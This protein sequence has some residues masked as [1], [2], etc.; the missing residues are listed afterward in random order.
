VA[1]LAMCGCGGECANSSNIQVTV[2]PDPGV[3][4]TTIVKLRVALA[5]NGIQVKAADLPLS[6]PLGTESAFLLRPASAQPGRYN[7]AVQI[8]ALAAHDVI[9]AS[10]SNEADVSGDGCNR[11]AARLAPAPPDNPG[12]KTMPMPACAGAMP[13]EDRD[14]LADSCDACPADPNA[15]PVDT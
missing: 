4:V 2:H 1:V 13:D 3:N 11:L 14:N 6:G 15:I 9:V 12:T 7:L 10:G 5:V 8:A